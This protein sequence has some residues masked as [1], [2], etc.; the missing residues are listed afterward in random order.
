MNP[1][2][3]SA[4]LNGPA[5]YDCATPAQNNANC[6]YSCETGVALADTAPVCINGAWEN[7]VGGP[8]QCVECNVP[9]DC[10]EADSTCEADNTCLAPEPIPNGEWT[11]G[12]GVATVY[13]EGVGGVPST[14]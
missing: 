10:P 8:P 5:F 2:E 7:G 4:I 6:T 9:E 14:A 13:V 11:E 1:P 3:A 12:W